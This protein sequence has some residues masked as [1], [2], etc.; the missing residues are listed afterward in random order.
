MKKYTNLSI[1]EAKRVGYLDN[2]KFALDLSLSP[3]GK[4]ILA[5]SK[6]NKEGVMERIYEIT[7]CIDREK[8]IFNITV[9][10][11]KEF[12]RRKKKKNRK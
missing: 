12:N 5:Y 8:K 1:E 4:D 11:E 3:K 10:S 9:M 6:L 2:I 7:E